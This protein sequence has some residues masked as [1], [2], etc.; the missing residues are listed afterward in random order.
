VKH[1]VPLVLLAAAPA[2]A[3][4]TAKWTDPYPGIRHLLYTDPAVPLRLN[5]VVVDLTSEEI[6]LRATPPG[7]RGRTVSDFA[8]CTG[9]G[10]SCVASEVAVNGDL[11]D[12]QGFVP[13]N[14]AI[15]DRMVW[16]DA[17]KDTDVEGWIAFG[18]PVNDLNQAQLA[19]PPGSAPP[20]KSLDADGAV[21]GHPQLAMAGAAAATFD[22]NDVSD[23]CSPRPRTAVGLDMT[24]SKLFVVVVDG[25]Q[26]GS[27]GMTCSDVAGFLL[28][29]GATDALALDMGASS[30]MYIANEGGE[31][32]QPSDGV[33][34][35][36][37]NH[38]GIHYGQLPHC[39]VVGFVFDSVLNGTK[40]T[41]A[42]VTLDGKTGGWDVPHQLFTFANIEPHYTCVVAK[43]PGFL[44]GQQC[45]QIT[46]AQIMTSSTQYDSVVLQRG[47]DPPDMAT[48]RDMASPPRDL[49][50]NFDRSLPAGDGAS[51]GG[52][53]PVS[54]GGCSCVVSGQAPS[55]GG[56]WCAMIALALLLRVRRRARAR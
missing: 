36:V 12:P 21:G 4:P 22:C 38:L 31:V 56:G 48:V 6:H 32:A 30:S 9:E 37:A 11:F 35:L 29:N 8:K 44:T 45:K 43:A 20:P 5:M 15:G 18:R 23:P 16:P 13:A 41:N 28:D 39:D 55:V 27:V 52:D 25:D 1:L 26:A 17:N 2:A 19:A 24:G 7:E 46:L 53:L 50:R 51:D 33:E 34:R 42:S 54:P 3:A 40:L 14:L 49:A 10:Q 47:T